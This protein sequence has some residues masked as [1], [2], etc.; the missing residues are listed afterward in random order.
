MMATALI[1][2]VLFI[3]NWIYIKY[4]YDQTINHFIDT[5]KPTTPPPQSLCLNPPPFSPFKSSAGKPSSSAAAQVYKFTSNEKYLPTASVPPEIEAYFMNNTMA[6]AKQDE[7]L[8]DRIFRY[9]PFLGQG[10][11]VE[12]GARDGVEHSNTYA[13]EHG[14]GWYVCVCLC[15]KLVLEKLSSSCFIIILIY[16]F[17][18]R[19]GI[20]AEPVP[21]EHKHIK[22]MRP[23]SAVIDGAV[24]PQR[25]NFEILVSF[26]P[27]M[28]GFTNT[29]DP[30]RRTS[31]GD[32]KHRVACVTLKDLLPLFGIKH[33]N[34]LTVDTEGSEQDVLENFPWGDVT[35]DAV[36]VEVLKGTRERDRK[37]ESLVKMMTEKAGM[38][39]HTELIMSKQTSDLV[40]VPA[41]DDLPNGNWKEVI[42]GKRKTVDP[43]TYLEGLETCQKF[44]RCL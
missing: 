9:K 22:T 28:N 29:Y 40:F 12:F 34:L 38:R 19:R 36:L 23:C 5:P 2:A 16:F 43:E 24:C 8:W 32:R 14:L 6:Q 41:N 31:A 13:F 25:G 4:Y 7:L 37:R 35:V 21:S 39:V 33:V 20:L 3:W 1:C 10:V 11:F 18:C 17:Y 42:D 15:V 26:F 44:Q 30:T 27:G